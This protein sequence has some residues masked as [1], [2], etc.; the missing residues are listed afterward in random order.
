MGIYLLQYYWDNNIYDKN[1]MCELV[2][3]KIISEED[4]FNITRLRYNVIKN[5]NKKQDVTFNQ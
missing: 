3:Q 5:K 4:F 2:K 1:K